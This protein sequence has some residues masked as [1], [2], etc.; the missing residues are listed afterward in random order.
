MLAICGGKSVS[1]A[2]LCVRGHSRI[3]RCR[4]RV[5]RGGFDCASATLCAMPFLE[6]DSVHSLLRV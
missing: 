3:F 6:A 2:P 4:L 1:Y 5:K